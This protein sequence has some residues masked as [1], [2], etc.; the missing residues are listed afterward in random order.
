[1]FKN[2]LFVLLLLTGFKANAT[3]ITGTINNTDD[4]TILD[5]GLEFL[6]VSVTTGISF[7]AVLSSYLQ[8][9]FRWATYNDVI[10]LFN[11]FGIDVTGYQGGFFELTTTD[12]Q[13]D[14]FT[15][16]LGNTQNDSS[17][18]WFN[19]DGTL[20]NYFC[21]GDNSCAAGSFFNDINYNADYGVGTLLV[22]DRIAVSEP[23]MFALFAV[24]FFTLLSSIRTNKKS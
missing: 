1:M 13:E 15:A 10:S 2:L 24:G 19:F 20:G 7:S 3:F 5:N 17:Y 22:R 21:L 12:A 14:L 4:T 16:T 23:S 11:A 6:D 8:D 9:G 18:G